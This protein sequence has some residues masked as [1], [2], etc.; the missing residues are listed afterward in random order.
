MLPRFLQRL[1][2]RLTG[3]APPPEPPAKGAAATSTSTLKKGDVLAYRNANAWRTVWVLEVDPWPDGTSVAHCLSYQQL[4]EKPTVESLKHAE[5]LIWHSPIDADGVSQGSELIGNRQPA[6]DDL[7]GFAE[8]LKLTDFPRYLE[9]MGQDGQEIVRQANAHYLRGNELCEQGRKEEGIAEY[10]A[11]V[12]LFPLFFE[13]I[14]NRAF[15]R[16]E[17]GNFQ[18]ALDD[19]EQSLQVNPDGEAAFF[20]KGECL[21]RLGELAAAEAIFAEGMERFPG[22]K[23]LFAEFLGRVRA[24][25]RSGNK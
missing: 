2:A 23:A 9:L 19:F 14:D 10:D 12:E 18:E 1:A 17:L 24:Q 13:A 4:D 21:M 7:V 16:M 22:K 11:A 15:T 5:V 6:E 25:Q 8:Y 3:S 20:S